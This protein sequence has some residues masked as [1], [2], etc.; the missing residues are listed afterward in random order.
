LLGNTVMI[1]VMAMRASCA[2]ITNKLL[3][4]P[5]GSTMRG[6]TAT[7]GS[8]KTASMAEASAG[9]GKAAAVAWAFHIVGVLGFIG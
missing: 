9:K 2:G 4:W 8:R 6:G 1:L 5:T 3:P 7:L